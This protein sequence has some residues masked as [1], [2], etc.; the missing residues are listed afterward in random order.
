MSNGVPASGNMNYP[1]VVSMLLYLCSKS[2]PDIAFA[3]H[4]V[5]R[6]PFKPT[7]HYEFAL[8]TKDEGLIMSPFPICTL[9]II[10]MPTLIV[11]M[12]IRTHRIR[13]FAVELVVL[14][15]ILAAWWYGI[16]IC[17]QKLH[18]HNEG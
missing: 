1:A 14:L 2:C 13:A 4:Q 9:T 17:K 12:G 3:V 5:A 10:Q 8:G 11:S 15:W 18:F 6:Y 16:P 7:C